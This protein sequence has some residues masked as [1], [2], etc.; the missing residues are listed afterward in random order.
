MVVAPTYPMLWDSTIATFL[1]LAEDARILK[2]FS[3]THKRAILSGRRT[4][5]FRSAEKPNRL[6]G[7]NLGWF[8]IDE[9]A[10]TRLEDLLI[11]LG[12]LRLPPAR[13]W[14]T[15]TPRGKDFLYKMFVEGSK[16]DPNYDY[17]Q[18]S[19]RA[20]IYLPADFVPS[21]LAAYDSAF[22]SQEVDGEFLDDTFGRLIP[23]WQIDRIPELVRPDR[24]GGPRWITC[25]LGEGGGRDSTVILVGDDFGILFGEES[26]WD[27]PPAAAAKIARHRSTFDVRQERIV[28]D[29]GGGRGLDIVPYLEQ[30]GITEA[31]PY[32]GSKEKG[33][34]D[35]FENTRSKMAWRFRQAVDPDRPRP[36]PE[37]SYDPHRKPSVFDPD[38]VKAPTILQPPFCVPKDWALWDHFEQEA[39]ALK[40]HHK[41]RKIA[42]ENKED[43]VKALGHSPNVIDAVLMRFK[44]GDD[45]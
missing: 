19:S 41:G 18:C 26:K 34:G 7:P 24:P 21:L 31:I 3:R 45:V 35:K 10:L 8:W 12:R 20:N 36:V 30:H 15:T 11:M 32:R 44:L 43:L 9:G 40:W 28:Y 1:D 6:R 23:D 42:L 27:G 29:A 14:V 2:D 4:V 38:P 25:D 33:G 17:V 39:R 13:G 16:K 37:L 22:A 5:L